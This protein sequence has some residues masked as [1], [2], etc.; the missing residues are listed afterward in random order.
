MTVMFAAFG[1]YFYYDYKVGYKKQNEQLYYYNAFNSLER[2]PGVEVHPQLQEALKSEEAWK[3]FAEKQQITLPEEGAEVLPE[4][5]QVPEAWPQEL[6]DGYQQLTQGEAGWYELWKVFTARTGREIGKPDAYKSK[7]TIQSQMNWAIGSGVLAAIALFFLVR[8]SRRS[9]VFE[10][11][12][13]ISPDG[14]KVEVKNMYKIDQSRWKTKGLATI[15]YKDD[16][17]NE[18]KVKVDG[19]VYGQFNEGDPNNAEKLYQAILEGFSGEVEDVE[20]EVDEDAK[21]A[22]AELTEKKS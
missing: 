13:Y 9:M 2:Q 1:G 18:G 14:V 8:T 15:F 12:T 3:G 22:S 4:G 10:N 20:D 16:A 19:M 17:G 11:G 6:V 21:A 7:D 5:K